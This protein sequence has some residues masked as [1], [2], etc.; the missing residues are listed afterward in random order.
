MPEIIEE[1]IIGTNDV[2]IKD[3]VG[4]YLCRMAGVSVRVAAIRIYLPQRCH[5][6]NDKIV[7]PGKIK[8]CKIK[9]KVKIKRVI[10]NCSI[11]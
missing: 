7:L 9:I 1:E 3:V 2:L 6:D 11:N 5:N 10:T 4:M 8:I